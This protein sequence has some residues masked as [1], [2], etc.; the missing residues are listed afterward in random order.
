LEIVDALWR[1]WADKLVE[2][3]EAM[4]HQFRS[5]IRDNMHFF[6]DTPEG[7]LV[8]VITW[9]K[10]DQMTT[11]NLYGRGSGMNTTGH[12]ALQGGEIH[13]GGHGTY[14]R[15]NASDVPELLE[16]VRRMRTK[17][18]GTAPART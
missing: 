18:M 13:V 8:Q 1:A 17:A 12:I 14:H 2:I 3:I 6:H 7:E 11:V 15:F 4:D 9:P 5:E 10:T 16:F